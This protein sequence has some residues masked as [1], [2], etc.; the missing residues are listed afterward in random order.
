M[1][2]SYIAAHSNQF[3]QLLLLFLQLCCQLAYLFF[4]V[5]YIVL[6]IGCIFGSL[7]V[8]ILCVGKGKEGIAKRI[9]IL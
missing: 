2:G 6:C 4:L 1:H 5:F 9:E 8:R 7:K 3:I